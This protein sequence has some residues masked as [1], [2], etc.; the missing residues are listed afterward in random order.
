MSNQ[1]QRGADIW[2]KASENVNIRHQNEM[3]QHSYVFSGTTSLPGIF[4]QYSFFI[5]TK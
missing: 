3:E 5:Y 2:Y 1:N 4:T